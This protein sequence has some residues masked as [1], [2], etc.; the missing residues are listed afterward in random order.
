MALAMNVAGTCWCWTI[1]IESSWT[2]PYLSVWYEESI[3]PELDLTLIEP[4]DL[5]EPRHLPT[6]QQ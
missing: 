2:L 3:A 4:K 5:E 1:A 6:T